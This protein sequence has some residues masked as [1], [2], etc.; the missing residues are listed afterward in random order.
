MVIGGV[1]EEGPHHC[2]HLSG[3]DPTWNGQWGKEE[4]CDID[5]ITWQKTPGSGKR[6]RRCCAARATAMT[7]TTAKGEER[8]EGEVD[9]EGR[10][11]RGLLSGPCHSN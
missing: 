7:T 1:E 6:R 10:G 5:G 4:Q 8:G 2:P 3:S 11:E 9:I